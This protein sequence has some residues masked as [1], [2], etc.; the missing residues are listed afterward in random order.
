MRVA[1]IR[2]SASCPASTV[3]FASASIGVAS[4]SAAP[5]AAT[6][7]LEPTPESLLSD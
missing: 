7:P 1:A 5:S 3:F 6:Q 2:A 4:V